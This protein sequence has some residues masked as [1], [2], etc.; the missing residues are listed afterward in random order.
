MFLS[1]PHRGI[2]SIKKLM[3]YNEAG[4]LVSGDERPG[5]V[6][7]SSFDTVRAVVAGWLVIPEHC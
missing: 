2:N 6:G 3:I 5:D 4:Q 7:F 1:F